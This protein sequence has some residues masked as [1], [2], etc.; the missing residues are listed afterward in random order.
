MVELGIVDIREIIRIIK[1]KYNF[2][3][4]NFALTSLKYSLESVIFQNS[5]NSPESLLRRLID[6]PE[7]IDTFIYQLSVPSTEMFRDPSLWRWM[8][9][10]IFE[11]E[12][13]KFDNFKIWLPY[14]VSGGELYTLCIALK[15]HDLLDKVRIFASCL[16]QQ[17]IKYIKSGLYPLK[18]IEVSIENYTRTQA[19]GNFEDYYKIERNVAIRDTSLIK[20]VEFI[21]DDLDFSKG[22][23]NTKLILMRNTL[24]YFNPKMQSTVLEKIHSY[25]SVSGYLI[26]GIKER[27]KE[28][29][30]ENFLFEAVD[31][32]ESVYKKKI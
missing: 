20:N 31:P 28:T 16:T 12:D 7:F 5:F 15:E 32:I 19:P 22:P 27:V 14:C 3:L 30:A 9:E 2:D 8:N 6:D 13:T 18:K 10:N 4:S 24:I 25:L 1:D 17:A 26:I 23:K 11:N 29:G 21:K